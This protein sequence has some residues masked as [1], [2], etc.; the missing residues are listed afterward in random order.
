MIDEVEVK[1]Y[2]EGGALPVQATPGAAGW[3]LQARIDGP[4][5]VA[6]GAMEDAS[7]SITIPLDI[8]VRQ[9]GISGG[10]IGEGAALATA[11]V[12]FLLGAIMFSYFGLQR[13]AWQQGGDK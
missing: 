13:R 9:G 10:A 11:M 8:P 3:D 12:P 7:G 1:V 4:L 6:I 2:A 5:D